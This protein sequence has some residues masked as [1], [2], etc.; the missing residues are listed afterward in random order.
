MLQAAMSP[1]HDDIG[2]V[3]LVVILTFLVLISLA[4]AAIRKRKDLA[5]ADR[6]L[7]NG[8]PADAIALFVKVVKDEFHQVRRGSK[9]TATFARALAGL[10]RAFA[11]AGRQVDWA[12]LRELYADMLTLHADRRFCCVDMLRHGLNWDGWTIRTRIEAEAKAFLDELPSLWAQGAIP[13][14]ACLQAQ[15]AGPIDPGQMGSCTGSSRA[16]KA[17]L[18]IGI[19][20]AAGAA[21]YAGLSWLLS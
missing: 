11:T 18:L 13:S 1:R 17:L 21:T 6:A 14:N 20:L 16:R 3:I 4:L 10:E 8:R 5:A 9:S 19:P 7:A 2:L 12:R 15:D